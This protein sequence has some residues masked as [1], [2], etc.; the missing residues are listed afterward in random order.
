[1]VWSRRQWA[2]TIESIVPQNLSGSARALLGQDC[3][4]SS[5]SFRSKFAITMN[6]MAIPLVHLKVPLVDGQIFV[7]QN[8]S[9]NSSVPSMTVPRIRATSLPTPKLI[10]ERFDFLHGQELHR[11]LCAVHDQLFNRCWRSGLIAVAGRG[12][13]IGWL[14]SVERSRNAQSA[15]DRAQSRRNSWATTQSSKPAPIPR[16]GFVPQPKA[17]VVIGLRKTMKTAV[18]PSVS[19]VLVSC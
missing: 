12:S 13:F 10:H 15:L 11:Y 14:L 3:W 6:C 19:A 17:V 1:V 8:Q 16:S 7:A 4:H 9:T 18:P 5:Y 2:S